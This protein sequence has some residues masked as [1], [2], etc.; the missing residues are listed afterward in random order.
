[1]SENAAG[2]LDKFVPD[3]VDVTEIIQMALSGLDWVSRNFKFCISNPC[4]FSVGNSIYSQLEF[5][6]R[7]LYSRPIQSKTVT[8]LIRSTLEKKKAKKNRV[9]VIN[10]KMSLRF[11]FRF[12]R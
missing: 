7:E 12:F 6:F 8:V 4:S 11:C 1:M 9:K 10:L 5:L 2:F 3:G